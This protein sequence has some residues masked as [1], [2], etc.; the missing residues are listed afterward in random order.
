MIQAKF[1]WQSEDS[2]SI[3]AGGARLWLVAV[4]HRPPQW[5]VYDGYT[6]LGS[7]PRADEDRTPLGEERLWSRIFEIL[8]TRGRAPEDWTV[9]SSESPW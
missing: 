1:Y 9:T 6:F 7:T 8:E 3:A 2:A 5:A 4:R